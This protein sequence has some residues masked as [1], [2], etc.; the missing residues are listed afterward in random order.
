VTVIFEGVLASLAT[1]A[2]LLLV[3]LI[4]LLVTWWAERS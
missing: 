1:L 2:M 4:G 3:L